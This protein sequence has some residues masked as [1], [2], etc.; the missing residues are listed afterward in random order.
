MPDHAVIERIEVVL[1]LPAIGQSIARSAV[2][3]WIGLEP[4]DIEFVGPDRAR[5]A[6]EV[7]ELRLI[8][9]G[10][11]VGLAVGRLDIGRA[12]IGI[13][14]GLR[15][16]EPGAEP[17]TVTLCLKSEKVARTTKLPFISVWLRSMIARSTMPLRLASSLPSMMS[18]AVGVGVVRIGLQPDGGRRNGEH[19]GAID[20]RGVIDRRRMRRSSA[21][22]RRHPARRY[23]P[24]H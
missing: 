11:G 5:R 14:K 20:P 16:L 18:S 2:T 19:L 15:G 22:R 9:P 23:R 24:G 3:A 17:V 10:R 12:E 1:Q 7:I 21:A 8:E 4:D 6:E 13:L